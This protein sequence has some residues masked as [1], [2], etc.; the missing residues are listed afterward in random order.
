MLACLVLYVTV[1]NWLGIIK[2]LPDAQPH[3]LKL[4]L[5][6]LSIV[7]VGLVAAYGIL[8]NRWWG[9]FAELAILWGL[10]LTIYVETHRVPILFTPFG[11]R[12]E[13]V[14]LALNYLLFGFW[15][16][17]LV[18]RGQARFH[19]VRAETNA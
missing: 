19:E 1:A 6:M 11:F 16:F 18:K 10:P 13:W 5:A 17:E 3:G 9:F 7:A 4:E 2:P 8:R 14:V 15:S 12:D